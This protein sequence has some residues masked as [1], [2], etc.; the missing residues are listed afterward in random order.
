M[1]SE[2]LT[3]AHPF[4]PHDDHPSICLNCGQGMH[5]IIHDEGPPESRL[6]TA[7]RA[8]KHPS[9]TW[10]LKGATKKKPGTYYCPCGK[11]MADNG[12]RDLAAR[13]RF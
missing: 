2:I 5:A 6:H 8:C 12:P 9:E 11:Q 10:V 4:N 13:L 3:Q 7:M 1:K